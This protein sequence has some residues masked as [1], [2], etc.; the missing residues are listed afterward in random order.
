MKVFNIQPVLFHQYYLWL[1]YY[2]QNFFFMHFY[3][4]FQIHDLVKFDKKT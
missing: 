4:Y 2:E 3:F 1:K